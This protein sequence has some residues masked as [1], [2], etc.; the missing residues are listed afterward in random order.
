MSVSLRRLIRVSISLTVSLSAA[1]AYADNSMDQ[2]DN[3][4]TGINERQKAEL[5]VTPGFVSGSSL[6]GLLRNYYL[7]RDNHNTPSRRDQRE[8]VQG[9][10]L[11][12]RSGYTDTPIGVGLDVHG[13]YGLKL[14]GGGGSGGAGLLPL[15]S[16]GAPESDFS[17]AG[18]ALKLRGFDS[19]MQAGDQYLENPLI[20]SGVSRVFPQTFRGVTLKNYSLEHLTL[21]TGWIDSTRQ[22]N[23]SGQSH[24][25]T[26]YGTGNKAGVAADRESASMSW[27]GGVYAVPGGITLTL[28]GGQLSDIWNQYYAGV[29][30]PFK[31]T[32]GLTLTPYLRYFKTRDQGQRQLG[33]IDNNTYSGGLT[34]SGAGQS[35]TLGMQ[36]VD[37]DTPFDYMVQDDR[38]F[39]YLGNSQQ[40]ADFN[41]PGEKSWKIQY[42]TSLAFIRAPDFQLS[43]SY[44][45][46]EAD[47]TR[48]DPNSTGYGY[49][50]NAAGKDAHHWERDVALRYGVPDG[51]AKG[52]NITLRWAAHRSAQGYT[53]PGNTRGN[54]NADEYRVIVDYPFS[55][56]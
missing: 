50:Y 7:G 16:K 30:Q 5:S 9:V 45:R 38:T 12:F 34:L 53:A 36:K 46:G 26:S 25:T 21:D 49:I 23:Q 3:L 54:S 19:L 15:D 20:A 6:N 56:F 4:S 52:L 27:L 31:L 17:A 29:S 42:Q 11:S 51:K 41:A 48:V 8:W 43:T 47:L 32:P 22:R 28:Y 40:Y 55:V 39:L 37:G 1:G 2:R 13:F 33:N 14:D 35:L 10:Y 24:L 18:A 44:T